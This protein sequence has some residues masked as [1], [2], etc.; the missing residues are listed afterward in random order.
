[1]NLDFA[2]YKTLLLLLLM[3]PAPGLW[4]AAWAGWRLHRQRRGGGLM[5]VL[6]LILLWLGCTEAMGELMLRA[7]G[8]PAALAPAQVDSLRGQPDGAVLVLGGGVR[9]EVPELDA[10]GLTIITAQRLGYGVWLARRSNW[11]LAFAGG[12][13]WT[14][15]EQRYPEADVVAR[16]AAQ[17]YQLPLR[18]SEGQSRDTRENAQQVLPLLARAGV[19]HVLLVTHDAHMK[20]SLRAFRSVAEPLGIVIT[21]A[22]V[23]LLADGLGSLS[24]WVPSTAGFERVRYVVYETLAYWAGH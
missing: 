16:V 14:A 5:L 13:G 17:D 15:R 2:A 8:K 3:P 9:R 20:R 23:G 19:K 12:I 18:W 7:V 22:P 24:D 10:P 4:L 1:M 11:P 21:A 6:A